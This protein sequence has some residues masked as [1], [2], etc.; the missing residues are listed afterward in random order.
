MTA[1][2]PPQS[3]RVKV[4]GLAR[5]GN[6]YLVADVLRNDGTLKGVRPLGGSVEFGETR[7]TALVREFAEE[8]GA[9]A[10]LQGGWAVIENIFDHEGAIGH[11]IIFVASVDLAGL[12][13][14]GPD[15]VIPFM[16]GDMPGRARWMSL[17][18]V[19]TAGLAFYPTGLAA[20]IESGGFPVTDKAC[21]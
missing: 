7:E 14:P 15:G 3:L 21:P 11:E 1:W 5:R 4:L 6:R 19:A 18:E 9:I 10:T 13:P 20:L 8:L 16:E 17:S 12:P 2:T